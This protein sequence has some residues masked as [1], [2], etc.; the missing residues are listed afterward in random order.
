VEVQDPSS[1]RLI[2]DYNEDGDVDAA[3]YDVWRK[4]FGSSVAWYSGADGNGDGI[5][6]AADYIIW[7]ND[8]ANGSGSSSQSVVPEPAIVVQ[9]FGLL[10]AASMRRLTTSTRLLLK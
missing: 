9:I 5:V 1:L 3:D 4:A 2:G 6:D 10:G 8:L 7:R